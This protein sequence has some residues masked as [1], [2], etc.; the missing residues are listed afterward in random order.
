[1]LTKVKLSLIQGVGDLD[2]LVANTGAHLD[3]GD[4][5]SKPEVSLTALN[6]DRDLG[7]LILTLSDGSTVN[8]EGFVNDGNMRLG[9]IGDYGSTGKPGDTGITGVDGSKGLKGPQGFRGLTGARGLTGLRGR[10]G[11]TGP[12]GFRGDTGL[13]GVTGNTGPLG[14]T[15]GTGATGRKGSDSTIPIVISETD[16]GAIGAGS[17]WVKPSEF[18]IND[19]VNITFVDNK[20]E[21]VCKD[22]INAYQAVTSGLPVADWYYNKSFS[23][24]RVFVADYV[25]S[26]VGVD[27][28]ILLT[29]LGNT[30]D[31]VKTI[32]Y[33]KDS[34][35]INSFEPTHCCVIGD[36]I[37]LIN[38]TG[39]LFQGYIVNFDYGS[40]NSVAVNN[41]TLLICTD[42]GLI[43]LNV[44]SKEAAK[45][46]NVP[47]S[48]C[49]V[50]EKY[51]IVSGETT[52][53]YN[54]D[55]TL[56]STVSKRALLHASTLYFYTFV[57][58]LLS[59]HL[60]TMSL[61][62]ASNVDSVSFNTAIIGNFKF[63]ID[64][65]GLRFIGSDSANV[66]GY[67]VIEQCANVLFVKEL[68]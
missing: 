64:Y 49:I 25:C 24:S 59:V 39:L 13:R 7:I 58:G 50:L 10:K 15:G 4:Y 68:A 36:E 18:N 67:T 26:S 56:D 57:D 40:I 22:T 53:V 31:G 51:Y 12:Q 16:P 52:L 14:I 60:P 46:L 34:V 63:K 1:M 27:G 44:H 9:R 37:C 38:D 29:V 11:D 30:I 41:D 47:C 54:F 28:Y 45:H 3:V 5:S 2:A 23:H 66:V 33:Y 65:M 19:P 55:F 8:V 61:L 32:C 21:D 48:Y 17:F 20:G 6:Y 35:F 43:A 42:T 62:Y